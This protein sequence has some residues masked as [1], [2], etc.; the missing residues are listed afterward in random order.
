MEKKYTT[1]NIEKY[2]TRDSSKNHDF[3]NATY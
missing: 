3:Q 2:A 1:Y